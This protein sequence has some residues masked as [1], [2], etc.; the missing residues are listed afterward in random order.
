M[1]NSYGQQLALRYLRL[2]F[3]GSKILENYRPEWLEG[4]E[5]DFYIAGRKHAFEFNGDQHLY[6]TTFGDPEEQRMRDK[7]KNDICKKKY[8]KLITLEA[9]DL[10]YTRLTGRIKRTMTKEERNFVG[11]PETVAI[12]KKLNKEAIEYRR[13]LKEKYGAITVHRKGTKI[14]E[15]KENA[16]FERIYGGDPKPI[17]I[18]EQ[19]S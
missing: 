15:E 6:E 1:A 11:K 12:L 3:H 8:I 13:L 2:Y 9:C 10:E 17:P 4:L 5:L 16:M 14:R 19:S 7:I 18:V